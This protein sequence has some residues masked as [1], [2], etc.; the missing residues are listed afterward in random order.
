MDLP[1]SRCLNAFLHPTDDRYIIT[2]N[3]VIF[4]KIENSQDITSLVSKFGNDSKSFGF[5]MD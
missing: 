3:E 5:N 2:F 1:Q 4:P